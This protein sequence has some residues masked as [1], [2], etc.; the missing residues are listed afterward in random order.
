MNINWHVCLFVCVR[1]YVWLHLF[2]CVV[3]LIIMYV[4]YVR[5]FVLYVRVYVPRLICGCLCKLIGII[6][7]NTTELSVA[8]VFSYQ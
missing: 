6:F 3:V 1:L 5:L 8:A 4:L 7:F 2:V